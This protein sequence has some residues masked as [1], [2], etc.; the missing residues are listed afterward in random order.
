MPFLHAPATQTN[1]NNNNDDAEPGPPENQIFPI[2]EE[3]EDEAIDLVDKFTRAAS[4]GDIDMMRTIL[5]EDGGVINKLNKGV[6]LIIILYLTFARTN[7]ICVVIVHRTITRRLFV[8][9]RAN[10]WRQ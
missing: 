10:N 5:A 4:T 6:R 8:Q 1:N 7:F 9:R 2:V 3:E